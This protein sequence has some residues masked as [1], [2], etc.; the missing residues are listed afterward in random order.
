[1][2]NDFHR[3]LGYLVWTRLHCTAGDVLLL[4]A[5]FWGVSL[6]FRTRDWSGRSGPAAAALFVSL[7]LAYTAWSELHN[8]QIVRTWAYSPRMPVIL[9]IGLAPLLQWLTLPPILVAVLRRR[10]GEKAHRHPS[11]R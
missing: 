3:S 8:T 10:Q 4:L 9:G 1:M 7:G 11:Q 6:A 2:Y 5:A